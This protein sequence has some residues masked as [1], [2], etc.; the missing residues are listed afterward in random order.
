MAQINS[1]V[2]T[3]FPAS[4]DTIGLIEMWA[5]KTHSSFLEEPEEVYHL[6]IYPNKDVLDEYLKLCKAAE[7]DFCDKNNYKE[8]GVVNQEAINRI[9]NGSKIVFHP[10]A[11][12]TKTGLVTC[13]LPDMCSCSDQDI[14]IV[15]KTK[16]DALRAGR[17]ICAE[18]FDEFVM[19]SAF[20]RRKEGREQEQ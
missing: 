6:F 3:N 7:A 14:T 11:I 15:K 8:Y 18:N 20:D 13:D 1:P 16:E 17:E 10:L 4:C 9:K 12:R 2:Q 5:I 19:R